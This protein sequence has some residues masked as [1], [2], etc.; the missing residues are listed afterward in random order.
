MHT[1]TLKLILADDHQ[2]VREGLKLVLSKEPGLRVIAEASNGESL[3]RLSQELNPDVIITDIKM[4]VMD[5]IEATKRIIKHNARAKILAISFL[6]NEYSVIDM[7]EAGALGYMVKNC[8]N[9]EITTAVKSVA[10]GQPYYCAH[11]SPLLV[12]LINNSV[13]NPYNR[14]MERPLFKPIERNIINLVCEGKTSTEI[15][16]QLFLSTR[17]IEGYRLRI[18]KKMNV[19]N[20]AGMIIY[21]VKTGLYKTEPSLQDGAPFN[22]IF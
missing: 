13:F 9:D 6:D 14:K 3:V 22:P 10:S 17:T 4:P 7:L 12:N 19:H 5:G 20:P 18:H 2:L 15:A 16:K 1:P 21:A 11:T 8:D